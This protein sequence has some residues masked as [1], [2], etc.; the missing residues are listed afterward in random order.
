MRLATRY[1]PGGGGGGS[2]SDK[3]GGKLPGSLIRQSPPGLERLSTR[4]CTVFETAAEPHLPLCAGAVGE[5]L[6]A[7]R[8]ASHLLDAIVTHRSRRLQTGVDIRFMDDV[9]LLRAVRPH[10]GEA[11]RLQLQVGGEVVALRRL[12]PF[13]MTHPLLDAQ[14]ILHVVAKLMCDHVSLREVRGTA[15]QLAQ[16][17]PEPQ[18]DIH[19]LVRGTVEGASRGLRRAAA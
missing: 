13:Q 14:Q 1:P 15:A 9:A 17:I 18:V 8:A 3:G 5:A 16:F 7:D 19:L 11:V 2:R 10:T 12:L 6:R 4:H